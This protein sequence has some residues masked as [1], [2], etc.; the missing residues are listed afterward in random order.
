MYKKTTYS[1]IYAH[2]ELDKP[3]STLT[4]LP[5]D[6]NFPKFVKGLDNGD[7]YFLKY[8]IL[9]TTFSTKRATGGLFDYLRH[10]N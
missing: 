9:F 1:N 8:Y 7:F 6:Q 5:N 3:Y 4:S 2:L 10:P